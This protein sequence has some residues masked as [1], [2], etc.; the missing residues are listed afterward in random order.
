MHPVAKNESNTVPRTVAGYFSVL[1]L[2]TFIGTNPS[3]YYGRKLHFI[4]HS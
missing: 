1:Y 3:P 2:V 4:N